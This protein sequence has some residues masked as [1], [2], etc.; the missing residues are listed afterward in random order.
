MF[1]VELALI[2]KTG[3]ACDDAVSAVFVTAET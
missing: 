1:W 2:D 3:Y